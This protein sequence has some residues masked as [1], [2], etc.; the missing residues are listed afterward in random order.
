MNTL[1]QDIRYALRMLARSPG[2]AVIAVLTLML[3][4]GANTALFS[5]VNGVLLNPLPYPH[6]EQLIELYSRTPDFS[7]SSISYPNF[8]D[9]QRQNSSFTQLAAFRSDTFNMTGRGEPEILQTQMVSAE[10][11]PLLNVQPAIGRTFTAQDDHPGAPAVVI[12][13]NA[14]WHRRFGGS[15]QILGQTISL[16][17]IAYTVIGVLPANFYFRGPH[18]SSSAIYIPLGQWT[19][20][21]FL[22]RRAG[23]GMNAVG[24]LKP[25]LTMAQA[26]ADMDG[27]AQNLAKAYPDADKNSGITLLTLKQD[28]V[29]DIAPLLYVL[30]AAVGFVLLI[31]CVNIANLLLARSTGRT[32]E[33]AIRAALGAGRGRV[34]RQL[35]TESVILSQPCSSRVLRAS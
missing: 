15:P 9:W 13:N 30:L 33:F 17:D 34:V 29:G 10:L 16:N 28:M 32:R 14:F 22:D 8:L 11:F 20:K 31:A 18:F 19:D 5:V 1:M 6:P 21:T 25:G 4:I 23:M 2:F 24:R 26:R 3:G 12:L 35:L 7:H 27:V